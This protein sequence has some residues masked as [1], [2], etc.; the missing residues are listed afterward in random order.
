MEKETKNYIVDVLALSNTSVE[1]QAEDKDG[2][3]EEVQCMIDAQMITFDG[4]ADCCRFD[5]LSPHTVLEDAP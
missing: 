5:E 3:L 1:V 2:A 4:H